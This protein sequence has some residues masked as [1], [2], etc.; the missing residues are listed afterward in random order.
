M[1][2]P[3]VCFREQS[4]LP[5]K[6]SAYALSHTVIG[7]QIIILERK[8]RSIDKIHFLHFFTRTSFLSL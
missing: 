3:H 6:K 8:G 7:M 1:D 4:M 5:N 2:S